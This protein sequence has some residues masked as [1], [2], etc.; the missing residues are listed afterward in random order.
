MKSWRGLVSFLRR[1]GWRRGLGWGVGLVVVLGVAGYFLGLLV[2]REV[3]EAKL[4]EKSGLQ[5]EIGGLWLTADGVKVSEVEMTEADGEGFVRLPEASVAWGWKRLLWDRDFLLEGARLHGLEV[6]LSVEFLAKQVKAR[7]GL[8]SSQAPAPKPTPNPTVVVV[9]AEK[10]EEGEQKE[11][12]AAEAPA[13]KTEAAEATAPV[14]KSDPAPLQRATLAQLPFAI[15]DLRV[16]LFSEKKPTLRGEFEFAEG[17]FTL[18]GGAVVGPLKGVQGRAG[19]VVLPTF[20]SELV[21][22]GRVL[23]MGEEAVVLKVSGQKVELQA[24]GSLAPIAG[25]PFE[26]AMAFAPAG[27]VDLGALTGEKVPAKAGR[28]AFSGRLQSYLQAPSLVSGGAQLAVKDLVFADPKD[29]SPVTFTKGQAWWRLSPA[30][31][32]MPQLAFLGPDE[33]VLGNGFV[34]LG[35]DNAAVLRLVASPLRAENYTRR[36]QNWRDG[37]E[38]GM[39]PMITPDRYFTDLHLRWQSGQGLLMQAAPEP[40]LGGVSSAPME[41]P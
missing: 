35:G 13:A 1:L 16:S 11:A 18:G 8:I 14:E 17:G 40:E 23:S 25:F 2:L 15:T 39:V 3:V 20:D 4:E 5:C 34:T 36:A 9:P 24:S 30:G 41:S 26:V 37:V 12:S 6:S 22:D 31:L 10:R 21:W 29:G 28:V 7:R 32:E 19:E 38:L 27:A 33:A